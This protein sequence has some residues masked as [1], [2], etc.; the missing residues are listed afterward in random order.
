LHRIVLFSFVIAAAPAAAAP[1]TTAV[2]YEYFHGPFSQ[3]SH[4]ALG[5][6]VLDLGTVDVMAQ[7]ARWRDDALGDGS[8]LVAGAGVTL[9]GPLRARGR[10]TRILGDGSARAWLLR[11]G[12]E[13]RFANT[14]SLAAYVERYRADGG[15]ATHG[16]AGEA[17]VAVHPRVTAR[18]TAS[19]A[20][21]AESATSGAGSLGA[22]WRAFSRVDLTAEAGWAETR[23]AS[24]APIPTIGPGSGLPLFGRNETSAPASPASVRESSPT[25]LL[26]A[27]V[28]FP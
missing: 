6:A 21:G 13:L 8:S 22:I 23:G 9:A 1:L 17:L 11:A 14:A 18:A 15:V 12:P 20:R 4:A 27:R 16:F 25:I 10:A 19:Y 7:G 5:L 26:G 28:V 24:A 3:N 2:G